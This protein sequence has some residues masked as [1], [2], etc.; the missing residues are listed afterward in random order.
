ML[1][2]L[3]KI[4]LELKIVKKKFP[5]AGRWL[6]ASS[7]VLPSILWLD[8]TATHN[9][10]GPSAPAAAMTIEG[11]KREKAEE[12]ERRSSLLCSVMQRSEMGEQLDMHIRS[13]S[14]LQLASSR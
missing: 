5:A 14:Q 1:L 12:L 13:Q 10:V 3:K 6:S 2:F 9:P 7:D 4:V 11:G 8:A